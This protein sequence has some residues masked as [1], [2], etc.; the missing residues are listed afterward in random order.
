MLNIFD[1]IILGIACGTLSTTIASGLPF[2]KFRN[3]IENKF[4]DF[5]GHFVSCSYC[6]GHWFSIFCVFLYLDNSIIKQPLMFTLCWLVVT[7]ISGLFSGIIY[8]LFE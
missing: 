4:G 1:F 6:L 8:K 2:L 3:F 7:G 5:W